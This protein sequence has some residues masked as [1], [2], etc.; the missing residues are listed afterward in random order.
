MSRT[1]KTARMTRIRFARRNKR[2]I[3]ANSRFAI[4]GR[5]CI[6][7]IVCS[8]AHLEADHFPSQHV[9]IAAIAWIAVVA[10]HCMVYKLPEEIGWG[11]G[12]GSH[13]LTLL[14]LLEEGSLRFRHQLREWLTG[15]GLCFLIKCVQTGAVHFQLGAQVA[16]KLSQQVIA[17]ARLPSTGMVIGRNQAVNDR[18]QDLELRWS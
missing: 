2:K 5:D 11:D 15:A 9:A 17:N 13:D 14:N 7:E 16:L 3:R 4:R 6:S 18:A 8:F 10:F 1:A 12:P